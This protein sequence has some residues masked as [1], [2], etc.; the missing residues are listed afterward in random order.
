MF[1][2]DDKR[3]AVKLISP[4]DKFVTTDIKTDCLRSLLHLDIL[5][6]KR[7]GHFYRWFVLSFCH[8]CSS[9]YFNKVSGPVIVYLRSPGIRVSLFNDDFPLADIPSKI[10]DQLLHTLS[11]LRFT[12]NFETA[13]LIPLRYTLNVG[14]HISIYK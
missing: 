6:F 1:R 7:T 10:T 2:N 4:G 11:D 14:Y 12:I 13:R 8:S 9:Y 5:G 3:D